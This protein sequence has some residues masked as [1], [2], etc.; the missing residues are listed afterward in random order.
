MN[1]T[2]LYVITVLVW[3]TT[4]FAIKLQ[5]G[6]APNEI[7]ILY[8]SALAAT[9]LLAWCKF[10]KFSL[11]F[12]VI[13]HV[14]LC[15]LG[16]SMFSLHYLFVYN[17]TVYIVSGVV[18]VV[19]SGMCFLSILNNY[20]FY[21]TK[22]SFNLCLGALIGVS[23]LCVF[24]WDEI[25]RSTLE[26]NTLKGLGLAAIG[27]I[28]FSLGSSISRRNHDKGL[29]IIPSMAIGMVYG[30]LAMLIYAFA[31]R[32]HF[33]LPKSFIYWSSLLYLVIPG[34][35]VAFLC[36]LKLIKNIGPELASYTT[37]LFPIVALIVSSALEGYTWSA[38]DLLGLI[39]VLLGNIIVMRKKSLK[40]VFIPKR[41]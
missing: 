4:W 39:L 16:L 3:G 13:D 10:K 17:A 29:D 9:F 32:S 23:G 15:A 37:V 20:I 34:S 18:A 6:L 31:Q 26:N 33:V 24:F 36:Y 8:R 38:T 35:I 7:S 40:G 5:V 30:T 14:F 25:A 22:P 27:T 21:R 2:I 11:Q 41:K 1:N 28:I 19:F 12:K